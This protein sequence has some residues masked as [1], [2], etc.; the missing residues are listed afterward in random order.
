MFNC[1]RFIACGALFT[2]YIVTAHFETRVVETPTYDI[3]YISK[4]ISVYSVS[5]I[6]YYMGVYIVPKYG[7]LCSTREVNRIIY[8]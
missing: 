7:Q 2:Y 8:L 3:R 4:Y 6:I 1:Q 5:I